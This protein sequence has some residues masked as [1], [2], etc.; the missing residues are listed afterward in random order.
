MLA[1]IVKWG[2]G[3]GIRLSKTLLGNANMSD[4]DQV[5]V[6]AETGRI[7][8]EKTTKQ[9][10]TLQERMKGYEGKYDIDLA[11]WNEPA[12]KEVW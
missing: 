8:I 6:I 5:Q 3:R 11:D 2:N 12:G 10:K 4:N 1:R 9:H 7:I